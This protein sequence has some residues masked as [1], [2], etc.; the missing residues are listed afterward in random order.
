MLLLEWQ[1]KGYARTRAGVNKADSLLE[2]L[3][4]GF[5]IFPCS[6]KMLLI[7]IL[8]KGCRYFTKLLAMMVTQNICLTHQIRA[9][10]PGDSL[11]ATTSQQSLDKASGNRLC[12]G[13][14]TPNQDVVLKEA[15]YK[16][17]TA[18]QEWLPRPGH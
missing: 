17:A 10:C 5:S 16:E 9:E 3:H 18:F 8:I 15:Y 4:R 11:L 14:S 7:L 6:L 2:H 13:K 1:G 12:V